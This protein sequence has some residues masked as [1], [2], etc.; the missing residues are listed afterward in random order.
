MAAVDLW[1]DLWQSDAEA[2]Q[3]DEENE[4]SA[5][6]PKVDLELQPE[7]EL[8]EWQAIVEGPADCEPKEP[9]Q[10]AKAGGCGTLAA[11]CWC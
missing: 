10:A 2:R 5:D 4:R 9:A 3:P 1:V 11:Q 7:P 8:G 6:D